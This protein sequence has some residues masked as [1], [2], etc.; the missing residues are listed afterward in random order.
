MISWYFEA[1]HDP[2]IFLYFVVFLYYINVTTMKTKYIYWKDE[3]FWLGYLEEYPDYQ[4][5][6]TTL[7]ELNLNLKDLYSDLTSGQIPNIRKKGELEV[8]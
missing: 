7:E 4:T 1:A 5:Q 8:A 6:G 3:D 2:F